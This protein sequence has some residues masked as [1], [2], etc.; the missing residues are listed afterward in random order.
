MKKINTQQGIIKTIIVIIIAI[1]ILSYYNINLNDIWNF[2]LGI[3][4][5]F[6]LTPASY[7]WNLWV[8]YIWTPFLNSVQSLQ[9]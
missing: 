5:N 8:Q 1:A 7:L 6:L 3:W 2:I 9:K 4:N